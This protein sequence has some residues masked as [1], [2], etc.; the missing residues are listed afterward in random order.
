MYEKIEKLYE[1]MDE[2]LWTITKH[3]HYNTKRKTY[4]KSLLKDFISFEIN[5]YNHT[6][7]KYGLYYYI[8]SPD[9]KV[10]HQNN[11][12][13]IHIIFKDKLIFSI[14]R[15][16][17]LNM[18]KMVDLMDIDFIIDIN[19]KKDL[20]KKILNEIKHIKRKSIFEKVFE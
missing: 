12:H 13:T 20:E 6:A 8:L 2:H 1:K 15:K 4:S 18:F 5:R 7:M 3:G 17:F 19:G 14:K 9:L 11:K 16:K 10:L